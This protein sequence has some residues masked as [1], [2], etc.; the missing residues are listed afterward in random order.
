MDK[1]D[2]D[3]GRAFDTQIEN[4][5]KKSAVLIIILSE[6]SLD[7]TREWCKLERNFFIQKAGG[8]N[9]VDGRIYLINYEGIDPQG[10]PKE[11]NRF[12]PYN[13][14]EHD[15]ETGDTLPAALLPERAGRF[16]KEL[17]S[18]RSDL[19]K[20]LFRL[21]APAVKA[22]A[23]INSESGGETKSDEDLPVVFLAEAIPGKMEQDNYAQVES[24]I[25]QFARVVPGRRSYFPAWEGFEEEIDGYLDEADLFVQLLSTQTWPMIPYFKEGYERWLLERAKARNVPALRWQSRDLD[26]DSVDDSHREFLQLSDSTFGVPQVCD[27]PEFIQ[28]VY[29]TLQK[30]QTRNEFR[31]SDD[32]YPV[33]VVADNRDKR[34]S[35][36]VGDDLEAFGPCKDKH[37]IEARILLAR[38]A[39]D[40]GEAA[41]AIL[42]RGLVIVWDEGPKE[43]LWNFMRTCRMYRNTCTDNPPACAVVVPSLQSHPV[44]LLPPRFD[45]IAKDDQVRLQKLARAICGEEQ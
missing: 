19:I 24:A 4:S 21:G 23:V 12:T 42:P 17:Y 39:P 6:A 11:I 33:L 26:I 9:S 25:G 38:D 32:G 20:S 13:F 10:L 30:K 28:I 2:V 45:V 40:A 43:Q 5:L 35:D 34:L 44:N 37:E 22:D 15:R 3:G 1:K 16:H 8:K 36:D 31:I 7:P 18:L 41:A 27:L 29:D 14:F